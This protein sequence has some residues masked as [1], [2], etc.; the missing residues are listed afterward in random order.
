M[1]NLEIGKL[2]DYI[3]IRDDGFHSDTDISRLRATLQSQGGF[4]LFSIATYLQINRK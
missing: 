2:Y 1:K 4:Y 3:I